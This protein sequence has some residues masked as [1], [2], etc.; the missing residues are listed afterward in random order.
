M[1]VKEFG[2][3]PNKVAKGA[4]MPQGDI[5]TAQRFIANNFD[6]IIGSLP[7][8]FDSKFKATGVTKSITKRF[9]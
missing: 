4:T 5:R 1:I 7:E 3:D 6:L 8:G 9:L 2:L